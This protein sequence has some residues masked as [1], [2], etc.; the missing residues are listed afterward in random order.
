M[1]EAY[2]DGATDDNNKKRVIN[3]AIGVLIKEDGEEITSISRKVGQGSSNYAEF[4]ALVTC[5]LEIVALGKTGEKVVVYGDLRPAVDAMNG[6]A[7]FRHD[8][9]W[10]ALY[11]EAVELKKLFSSISFVWIPNRKNSQAH[12]LSRRPFLSTPNPK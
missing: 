5:L 11:Q 12:D 10:F 4:F 9:E 1:I 7:S 3:C 2:F 6:L 8:I